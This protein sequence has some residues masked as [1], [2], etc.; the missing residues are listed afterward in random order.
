MY[1]IAKMQHALRFQPLQKP[2]P[3]FKIPANF[4]K[5]QIFPAQELSFPPDNFDRL[6]AEILHGR[7]CSAGCQVNA[8]MERY[9]FPDTHV[10]IDFSDL[11]LIY[12]RVL[13]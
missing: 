10:S 13:I 9:C 7:V 3:I 5:P 11:A 2:A 6:P 8:T 12:L 4:K 1:D